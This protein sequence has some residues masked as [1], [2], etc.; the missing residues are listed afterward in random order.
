MFNNEYDYS[1]K[2]DKTSCE[3]EKGLIAAITDH[4]FYFENIPIELKNLKALGNQYALE[5]VVTD[6][7]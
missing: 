6:N 2:N 5:K 3:N 1:Y 7:G 4:N